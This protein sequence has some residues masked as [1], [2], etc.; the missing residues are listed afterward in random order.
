MRFAALVPDNEYGANVVGALQR[1][2]E[3]GGGLVVRVQYYDPHAHDFAAVVRQLASYEA[4]RQSLAQQRAELEKRNDEVAQRRSGAST[5]CRPMA[6]YRSTP[7]CG[8]RRQAP[9][10]HRRPPA[11]L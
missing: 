7:C 4:R 1:T 10:G 9:A 2:A 6:T 11:V 5:P 8:R 3:A